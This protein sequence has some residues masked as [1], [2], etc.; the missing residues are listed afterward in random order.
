MHKNR[1][2]LH[3]I[4]DFSKDNGGQETTGPGWLG[5]VV[6]SSCHWRPHPLFSRPPPPVISAELGCM[7]LKLEA[8]PGLQDNSHCFA[9]NLTLG[10]DG[11]SSLQLPDKCP[12]NLRANVDFPSV[13]QT[14]KHVSK[15]G[16]L[17]LVGV[18]DRL[19]STSERRLLSSSVILHHRRSSGSPPMLL[20]AVFSSLSVHAGTGTKVFTTTTCIWG[21]VQRS[22]SSQILL[23]NASWK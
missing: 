11:T 1:R 15:G 4:E 7:V 9:S 17:M 2:L 22:A 14:K 12:N 5:V 20:G 10:T 13:M 3:R 19:G 8:V 18:P 6:G 16:V 21:R 23:S